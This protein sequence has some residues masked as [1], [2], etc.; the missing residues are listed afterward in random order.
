[1]QNIYSLNISSDP[2]SGI[3]LI[4]IFLA[5]ICI[6]SFA[7]SVIYRLS[8]IYINKDKTINIAFPR[9]FCPNCKAQ[10]K[11][12]YLVPILGYLIQKGKCKNCGNKIPFLYIFTELFFPFLGL[13][14][15][16]LYGNSIYLY[17]LLTILFIFYILFVLD[18]KFFYLP[19]Y[20][21]LFLIIVGF[22]TN[23]FFGIFITE[24]YNMLGISNFMFSLYGF[25]FGF[26]SLYLL[27][28]IFKIFTKKD[29]IGGGDFL[30]FGGI[31]S[32]FGPFS[33]G[34]I[35]LIA[36]ITGCFIYIFFK[37]NF[38]KELPLGS[39]LILASTLYFL[40]VKFELFKNYVVI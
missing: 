8:Y 12:I 3:E 35:L 29:G 20:I 4:S 11:L 38:K 14:L 10:L 31:G 9:S 18:L 19:I 6:G 30:L 37:K 32:I 28:L 27:N 22:S 25:L 26:I 16:T 39:C 1:M 7:S 2:V 36:S 34:L 15:I 5:S 17:V 33:L 40:L 21:N 24:I 23:I 13:L